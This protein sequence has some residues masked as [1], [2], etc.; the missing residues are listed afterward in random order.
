M[1]TGFAAHSEFFK[2]FIQICRLNFESKSEVGSEMYDVKFVYVVKKVREKKL[3]VAWRNPQSTTRREAVWM[4]RSG[5]RPQKNLKE[6][7]VVISKWD[8]PGVSDKIEKRVC[9]GQFFVLVCHS[10]DPGVFFLS[11]PEI[12]MKGRRRP[13]KEWEPVRERER[14]TPRIPQLEI[15]API[16]RQ[17]INFFWGRKLQ[18][19][20]LCLPDQEV[21]CPLSAGQ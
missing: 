13:R 9:E 5:I 10:R 7:L 15:I 12:L 11:Y 8:C 4:C 3:D 20:M 16:D 6:K 21:F 1:S 2:C 14:V 18:G 19:R 17:E